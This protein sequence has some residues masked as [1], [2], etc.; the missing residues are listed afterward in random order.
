LFVVR[1]WTR[2]QVPYRGHVARSSLSHFILVPS[3]TELT[4]E[5]VQ[6]EVSVSLDIVGANDGARMTRPRP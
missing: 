2:F 5:V 3:A 6:Y 1:E 4:A